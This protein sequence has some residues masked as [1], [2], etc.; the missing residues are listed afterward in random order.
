MRRSYARIER[1]GGFWTG[2]ACAARAL[3]S[4][5]LRLADLHAREPPLADLDEIALLACR[6][7]ARG[8][9]IAGD[10]LAVDGHRSLRDQAPCIVVARRQA[11]GDDD[12]VERRRGVDAHL[13]HVVG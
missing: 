8:G 9:V 1:S 13:R 11:G 3:S 2:P 6:Q 12:L 5:S 10:G 7:R 4:A